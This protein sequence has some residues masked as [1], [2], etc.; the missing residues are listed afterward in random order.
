M[1]ATRSQPDHR[2]EVQAL[3]EHVAAHLAIAAAARE[4]G[5]AVEELVVRISDTDVHEVLAGVGVSPR[6][7]VHD[8]RDAMPAPVARQLGRRLYRLEA[9]VDALTPVAGAAVGVRLLVDLGRTDAVGYYRG[10]QLRIDAVHE[11]LPREI[12]DGGSVDWAAQLLSDRHEQL[13]TSG[14]GLERLL[15]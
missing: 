11:G 10:L 8:P 9:A 6:P 1:S 7:D 12:A 2:A 5:A 15:A 14:V 3:C 13:F 4:L